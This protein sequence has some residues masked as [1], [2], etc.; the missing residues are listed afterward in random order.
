M[1]ANKFVL[2]WKVKPPSFAHISKYE[3]V[4]G[5]ESVEI[6][7]LHDLIREFGEQM[8]FDVFENAWGMHSR[9]R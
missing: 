7:W 9:I 3:I 8:V 2:A 6:P 1:R 4:D 5:D